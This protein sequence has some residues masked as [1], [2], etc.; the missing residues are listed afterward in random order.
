MLEKSYPRILVHLKLWDDL[1]RKRPPP[2]GK[3]E[4]SVDVK[5]RE[6]HY[7]P[8]DDG[9]P[10]VEK[11]VFSEMNNRDGFIRMWQWGVVGCYAHLCVRVRKVTVRTFL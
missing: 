3:I 4:K 6:L 10:V 5:R 1:L 8:C 9:W 7:E 2:M 11:P